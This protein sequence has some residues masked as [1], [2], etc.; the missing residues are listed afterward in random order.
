MQ[1]VKILD[2]K[3]NR[4][5]LD[6]VLATIREWTKQK[7]K[8]YIVSPNIEFIVAAQKDLEFRK[9]L[10]DADLSIPD[11]SRLGWAEQILS[12]KNLFKKI[13]LWP[14]F[15][16]PIKP[17]IKDFPLVTGVDLM[18]N[19]CQDFQDSAATIGLLGGQSGVAEKLSECL[20]KKYP[21]LSI[22]FVTDGGRVS[23]QGELDDK[24]LPKV[25][26]EIDVLFVAFGHIKQEKWIVK[27]I[28]N[29]PAKVFI[30]VGGAFDYLSGSIPRAPLFTRSLKLEWLFRL[31]FQPWRIKRFI[32]LVKF[33]FLVLFA[34]KS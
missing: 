16:L 21:K 2:V 23:L 15:I 3:V 32:S 13:L 17:F 33:V 7:S 4:V 9:I 12:E 34:A 26:M 10:N 5:D 25:K 30:G 11:S 31:I 19:I 18:E 29:F 6:D 22:P 27:N 14:F 24:N 20:I 28:Q 1:Q 8:H